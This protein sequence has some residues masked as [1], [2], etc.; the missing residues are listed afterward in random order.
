MLSAPAEM[1]RK[2]NSAN[3][4]IH[5]EMDRVVSMVNGGQV[6]PALDRLSEILETHPDAAWAL[7][8]RVAYCSIF[9]NTIR[10]MKMQ[11][12]SSDCSRV[13]LSR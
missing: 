8:V 10:S 4:R 11:N 3:A 6:V 12:V 1:V 9:V 7:A 2:S 13:I 5:P